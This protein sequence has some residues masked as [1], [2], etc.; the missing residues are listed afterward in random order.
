MVM[1][2]RLLNVTFRCATRL[3]C[4]KVLS[5]SWVSCMPL[6]P[7][8]LVGASAG[9]GPQASRAAPALE[10]ANKFRRL[11]PSC[12]ATGWAASTWPFISILLQMA[13]TVWP[14][15]ITSAWPTTNAASSEHSHKTAAATSSGRPIRPDRVPG[16]GRL[17]CPSGVSPKTRSIMWGVDDCRAMALMRMP[18]LSVVEGRRSWSRPSNPELRRTVGGSDRGKPLTPAPDDVFTMAPP[19]PVREQAESRASWTG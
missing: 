1:P 17:G 3:L 14:P 5:Q 2:K 7:V 9:R 15:S 10:I 4:G 19:P 6:P 18:A 13:Q 8:A 11:I 16:R 12:S